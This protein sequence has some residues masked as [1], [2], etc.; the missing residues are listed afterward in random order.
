MVYLR[1]KGMKSQYLTG[2]LLGLAEN[3]RGDDAKAF[4]DSRN[5][6]QP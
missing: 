3:L 2:G 1:S 6:L 4:I 5:L